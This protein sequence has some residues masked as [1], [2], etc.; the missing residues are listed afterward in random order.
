MK[1]VRKQMRKME[2][3]GKPIASFRLISGL[4]KTMIDCAEHVFHPVHC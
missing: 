4:E 2:A 3:E 1:K